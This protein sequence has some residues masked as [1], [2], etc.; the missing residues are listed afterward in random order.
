[1]APITKFLFPVVLACLVLA[2]PAAASASPVPCADVDLMPSAAN[3]ASV[4]QATLCLLNV[5]RHSRAL[6]PLT[7]SGQ[8]GKA[9]QNYSV[10]MVRHSFFDHVSPSGSTLSSRVRG[11]TSYLGGGVRSWSLGEN[12]GWGSGVLA[13]PKQIVRSWMHSGAHRRN[14]VHRRFRH[15]G[16]GVASGA[17]DDVR[18]LPA[19]TYTTDFGHRILG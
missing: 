7:A 18:G 14:I 15:V 10:S 1:M 2:L 4:K 5:E 8:L 19:A 9:A 13:T 17:P 12:L 6:A 16:I 11:G 3:R